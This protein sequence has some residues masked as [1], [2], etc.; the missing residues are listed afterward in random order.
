MANKEVIDELIVRIQTDY[1]NA[2]EGLTKFN[3][4]LEDESN[5][6][7]KTVDK[8]STL[9]T[10]LSLAVTA[11]LLLV[12]KASLDMSMNVV[13][14]ENLFEV[15][16]GKMAGAARVFSD[17]LNNA[18]GLNAADVRKNTA[19]FNAM[20]SSM[21]IATDQSY[22]MST[23]LTKL[24]YDLASFYN[25]SPDE[26]FNKLKSGITGETEPLK[27]LGILLDETTVK[28]YA[29]QNGIAAQGEELTQQE[30]VLARYGSLLEQ[31]KLAQGDLARTIDSPTNKLRIF[32]EEAKESEK[33]IGDNLTKTYIAFTDVVKGLLQEFNNFGPSTQQVIVNMGLVAAS[34]GPVALGVGQLSKAFTFLL[35][36]PVVAAIAAIGVVI[37]AVAIEVAKAKDEQ[38]KYNAELSETSEIY[39]KGIGTN[40]ID[41]A[42]KEQDQLRSLITQYDNLGKKIL[43]IYDILEKDVATPT[44]SYEEM[45]KYNDE[46]TEALRQQESLN[47]QLKDL[48][49]TYDSAK[50]RID[51]YNVAIDKANKEL[52]FQNE[53]LA[54]RELAA[55]DVAAI[56]R[57][58]LRNQ[59]DNVNKLQ[60][61]VATYKELIAN[62]SLSSQQKQNLIEVS[63]VLRTLLGEEIVLRD[64]QNNIIG[65]N[66]DAINTEVTA[67]ENNANGTKLAVKSKIEDEIAFTTVKINETKKRIEA[68][69]EELAAALKLY[70]GT[71]EL[72][73]KNK[74]SVTGGLMNDLA[75]S[76][77]GDT[78]GIEKNISDLDKVLLELENKVA[79]SQNALLSLDKITLDTVD[80]NFSFT[81]D[82]SGI[83]KAGDQVK[84]TLEDV[85]DLIS[86]QS[87][88]EISY[89]E[90]QVKALDEAYSITKGNI[91]DLNKTALSNIEKERK[92]KL[93]GIDDE[94]KEYEKLQ[95]KK[96]DDIDDQ[97]DKINGAARSEDRTAEL[98]K[99]KSLYSVYSQSTSSEGQARAAELAK[100]I[101][102]LENEATIEGL[103]ASK[104]SIEAETTAK[105]EDFKQQELDAQ[106]HYETQI[107]D[108]KTFYDKQLSLLDTQYTKQKG[109]LDQQLAVTQGQNKLLLEEATKY[110]ADHADIYKKSAEDILT[111]LKSKETD[112]Y[113]SGKTLAEQYQKGIQ[114]Q[115]DLVKD[116]ESLITK[117][118]DIPSVPVNGSGTT[119]NSSTTKSTSVDLKINNYGSNYFENE[120]DIDS[121][122][123][124]QAATTVNAMTK[125]GVL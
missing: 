84:D 125:A 29:Y 41:Q 72:A 49:F 15:S 3:K 87:E 47:N 35:A 24:A 120:A 39:M 21:K 33:I 85:N 50:T 71:M 23:G 51:A 94:R 17:E 75:F 43:G 19:V 32:N 64:S 105:Q 101:R 12:G 96:L 115:L 113:N 25:L 116:Y 40:Q 90:G 69:Q 92:D 37:G 80:N 67:I 97:I 91:E 62:E 123:S 11:P 16:M 58:L 98:S 118:L 61:L 104:K 52:Q 74:N 60:E 117:G 81:G 70:N 31:T 46:V 100:Q 53:I 10:K 79:D 4:T 114:D 42:K 34:I 59:E 109:I 38:K 68:E 86:K 22:E 44:L 89:I 56:D 55:R 77:F 7:L 63:E 99:A 119:N 57:E 108:Q 110:A 65:L 83:K 27:A 48:G 93:K 124:K 88:T 107:A 66:I 103:N 122:T 36:N 73:G 54:L 102:D 112:Y 121:F 26:A 82:T 111:I 9:G 1:S 18:L 6:A 8:L 95:K 2:T 14:S 5:K 45:T 30:K 78:K 76:I 13:E 28:T 20:F 106:T